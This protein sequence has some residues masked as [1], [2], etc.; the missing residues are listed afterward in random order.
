MEGW[1]DGFETDAASSGLIVALVS[2]L[3]LLLLGLGGFGGRSVG[4]GYVV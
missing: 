4:V 1:Q 3:L 2:G